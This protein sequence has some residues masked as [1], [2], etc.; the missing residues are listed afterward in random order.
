[1]NVKNEFAY[2]IT[3]SGSTGLAKIVK[4]PHASIVPNVIDLRGLFLLSNID[5]IAQT[6]SLTFDPCVV[7]IFL[8]LSSG[9]TLFVTSNKVMSNPQKLLDLI[10][11]YK[12]TLLQTTPSL[13]QHRW[14]SDEIGK[15]IFGKNSNLRVLL[16]GGEPLP[17]LEILN[18]LKHPENKTK[19]YNIYGITEVS[20]WASVTEI[21]LK[22]FY[23]F[24]SNNYLG[25]A[26]SQ[27]IFQLRNKQG[28]VVDNGEGILYIGS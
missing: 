10:F 18:A 15:S 11:E 7:E 6:T 28:D 19:I 25:K 20:C 12:V 13:L 21:D 4:V 26:L 1:M 14:T 3:T 22:I 8:G 27:T 23:E 5:K 9:G 17:K 16:L 24:E 2:A